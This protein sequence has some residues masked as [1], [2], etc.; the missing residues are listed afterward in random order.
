M[1]QLQRPTNGYLTCRDGRRRVAACAHGVSCLGE[2]P[3]PAAL[4]LVTWQGSLNG[5][6]YRFAAVRPSND[7][8]T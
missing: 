7:D 8:T 5:P 2:S 1:E 6:D 3:M 4:A